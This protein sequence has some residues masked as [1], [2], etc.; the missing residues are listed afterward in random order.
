MEESDFVVLYNVHQDDS[1][2]AFSRCTTVD[3][4]GE[5][6]GISFS[7]DSEHLYIGCG[8]TDRGGVIELRRPQSAILNSLESILLQ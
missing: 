1:G 6:A 3:F 8:E 7:P 2:E 4:F 5:T